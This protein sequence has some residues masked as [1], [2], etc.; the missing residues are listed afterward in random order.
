[1]FLRKIYLYNVI[2][3]ICASRPYIFVTKIYFGFSQNNSSGGFIMFWSVNLVRDFKRSQ[4]DTQTCIFCK[5]RSY[6]RYENSCY[7]HD[8]IFHFK[9]L[10]LVT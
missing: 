1:M 2:K 7:L 10:F 5:L 4:N 3:L 6:V 9:N 8:F